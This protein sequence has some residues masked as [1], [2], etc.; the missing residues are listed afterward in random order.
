MRMN[1]GERTQRVLPVKLG[2]GGPAGGTATRIGFDTAYL[3]AFQSIDFL[4]ELPI[5]VKGQ[6]DWY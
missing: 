6:N 3:T 2:G 1:T 5:W 4:M